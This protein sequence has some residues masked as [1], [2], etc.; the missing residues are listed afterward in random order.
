MQERFGMDDAPTSNSPLRSG[1]ASLYEGGTREP[2]IV[3]WP[4]VTR[5]GSTS[6][7]IIQ[8]TDFYPTLL[9][10]CGLKPQADQ[11]FD[12][13][14]FVPALEGGKST[15]DTLFCIFPH[16]NGN[17][18]DDSRAGAYVRQGDW[19]LIR[20]FAGNDDQTDK[21]E[22][23]N[24][25]DDLGE[26]KNLAQAM[27]GKVRELNRLLDGFLKDSRAVVPK[28]NPAYAH[29][30]RWSAG[31]DATL[32]VHDGK[33][34]V[35]STSNRPTLQLLQSSPQTGPLLL[36]F[37]MRASQGRNG[38]VLWGTDKAPGFSAERRAAFTA[39]Y[40]GQ[41][42]DYAVPFT[43][44]GTLRQL[45][46]D[47]SLHPTRLEYEWIRLCRADGTVLQSWDFAPLGQ[48]EPR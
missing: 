23:F 48:Q 47:G 11:K 33:A 26:T 16:L 1:K 28:P 15:R 43:P 30:D 6:D 10:M 46:T 25:H 37:R 8:S 24:L 41:W 22:L 12:G 45:R 20:R 21:V 7:A 4:G 17:P 5:P 9:E 13:V 44:E 29:P 14:S 31:T 40:D 34:T 42:H 3:I 32:A 27:P 18:G 38:L 35:E 2:C 19:K 36:K 39:Q